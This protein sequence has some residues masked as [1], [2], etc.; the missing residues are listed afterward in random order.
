[1]RYW[2]E[3]G[4]QTRGP[5][6]EEELRNLIQTGVL[7]NDSRIIQEGGSQWSTVAENASQ[8]GISTTGAGAGYTPSYGGAGSQTGGGYQPQFGGQ[9]QPY[10][11][12]QTGGTQA[13]GAYQP[14]YGGQQQPYGG[15][16]GGEQKD[17]TTALL[18]SI[19][20]GAFGGDRFYLGYTGLGVLKLL[21]LGGCGV[22]SIIDI[23]NIAT[24][25]MTD[26]QGRPLA[27][28]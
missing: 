21:T 8:L 25:K 2:Y 24:N 23:I 18:L 19:F 9:Q 6:E 26:A 17:W 12:G 13:G 16:P 20:L 5:V 10:G 1:M 3:Q 11:G 15:Q 22:W 4:G 28:K 14:Q 27:K 7:N